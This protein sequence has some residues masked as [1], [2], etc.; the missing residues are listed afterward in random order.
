MVRGLAADGR[1]FTVINHFDQ[2]YWIYYCDSGYIVVVIIYSFTN[3]RKKYCMLLQIIFRIII[4][5]FLF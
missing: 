3:D 1:V 5:I 4:L 2:L